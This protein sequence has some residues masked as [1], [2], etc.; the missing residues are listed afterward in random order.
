MRHDLAQPIT[1]DD[2]EPDRHDRAEHPAHTTGT[3]LL[4][5]N[6]AMMT[7]DDRQD[8]TLQCRHRDLQPLDRG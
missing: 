1:A 4:Q 6:S 5:A 8:Y 3:V 7:A 2:D